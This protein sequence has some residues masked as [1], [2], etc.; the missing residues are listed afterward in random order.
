MTSSLLPEDIHVF[1]RG[2][3][4][5]NNI[6]FDDG[7][8]SCLV[9]SGYSTH[10]D[11]TLTLVDAKLGL[12]PLDILINTHLHSDHCG[13]NSALQEKYPRLTTCIPPGQAEFVKNWDSAGLTY[14]ATG[15]QCPKFNYNQT[16]LP[17]T[18][19]RLGL[20]DWDIYAAPG[21]D[22][23]AVL[24]FEPGCRILI[25]GDALWESGF[26]VVFPE[27]EGTDAFD[28]VLATLELIERLKPTIVIPGHGR[29]FHYTSESMI[30]A[31]QRLEAFVQS[32]TRHARHAVKVLIK[33][34]LLEIQQQPVQ[35]FMQW[36]E[37]TPYLHIC[38]ERFFKELSF[39]LFMQQMCTELVT[40]GAARISDDVIYN[41]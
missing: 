1:E 10:S 15:Q 40:S 19:I 34:K 30:I 16:L 20:S 13:G 17:G 31:R 12:R 11:Q 27:L 18:H 41:T 4:S 33:F 28:E 6:F 21:H 14:D 37:A 22:P 23:D 9:D 29:V 3:L 39:S 38:K 25:S 24:L 2:W 26:G 7:Q 8:T 35:Q 32:P 5:S 36:A